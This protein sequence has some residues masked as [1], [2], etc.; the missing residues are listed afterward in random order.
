MEE[1]LVMSA[2]ERRRKVELEGVRPDLGRA[3][4]E[5]VPDAIRI[6]PIYPA[7]EQMAGPD[8]D[9]DPSAGLAELYEEWH[10]TIGRPLDPRQAEAFARALAGA[11][12]DD[13]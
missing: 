5:E 4:R 9:I 1:H 10:R 13:A 8:A 6:D 2:K 3:V 12:E 7:V 11:D